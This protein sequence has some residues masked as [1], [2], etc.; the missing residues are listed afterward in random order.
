MILSHKKIINLPVETKSGQLLG[1]ISHFDLEAD[2]H[3]VIRYY[4]K[5]RQLIRGLLNKELIIGIDQVVALTPEKM[6][7]EDNVGRE[8]KVSAEK[9]VSVTT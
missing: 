7:V 8:A 9:T 3:R 6:V 2:E 1:A 5:S 4:V